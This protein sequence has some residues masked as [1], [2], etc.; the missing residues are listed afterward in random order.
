MAKRLLHRIA[1]LFRLNGGTVESRR[2][3]DGFVIYFQCAGCDWEE[4][5][6]YYRFSENEKR[7]V[8]MWDRIKREADNG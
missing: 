5:H 8:A 2:T 4:G 6:D 3:A 7:E 1:H